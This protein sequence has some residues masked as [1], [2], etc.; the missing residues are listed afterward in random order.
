M[1]EYLKK[2]KKQKKEIKEKKNKKFLL[3]SITKAHI[4]EDVFVFSV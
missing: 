4:E 1:F 2:K 3:H